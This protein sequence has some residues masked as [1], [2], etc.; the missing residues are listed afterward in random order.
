MAGSGPSRPTKIQHQ[1][2]IG[3]AVQDRGLSFISAARLIFLNDP[4]LSPDKQQQN[5]QYLNALETVWSRKDASEL[6]QQDLLELERLLIEQINKEIYNNEKKFKAVKD[7]LDNAE[8]H[9]NW[10]PREPVSSDMTHEAVKITRDETPFSRFTQEQTYA[11]T[12]I[13]SKEE[14]VQ[15]QWFK[16][17]APWEQNALR[18]RVEAWQRQVSK[19]DGVANLGEFLGPVP[20][21]IRRYPG[22]PNV[23]HTKA[24]IEGPQGKFEFKKI[25]SGVIVPAKMKHNSKKKKKQKVAIT[26]QNLEQILAEAIRTK[27]QDMPDAIPKGQTLDIPVLLQTLYSPPFQPPG[28]TYNNEAVLKATKNVRREL[29][30][31]P[32]SYLKKIGITEKDKK[33]YQVQVDMLYSNKPV[34]MLRGISWVLSKFN[35]S[36]REN[37]KTVKAFSKHIK[38]QKKALDQNKLP[39]KREDIHRQLQIAE[40]ALAAYKE[41]NMFG[42]TM[43]ATTIG[44]RGGKPKAVSERNHN[45]M[46]EK[47][48][49]EQIIMGN[50]GVRLGSCVSG[51]DREEMITHIALAQMEIY[52]KHGRFPPPHDKCTSDQDKLIRAEFV[53]AVARQYLSGHGHKLA[54]KNAMGCDGLKNVQDVFG[55][56]ICEQIQMLAPEYGIDPQVFDPVV[57]TQR[58]AGLNKLKEKKL[59]SEK[60]S[61][62]RLTGETM[63]EIYNNP[64]RYGIAVQE[65][66]ASAERGSEPAPRGRPLVIGYRHMQDAD[67]QA[68]AERR[69]AAESPVPSNSQAGPSHETPRHPRRETQRE[70][71]SDLSTRPRRNTF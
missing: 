21:T 71:I 66:A 26:Q 53:T 65:A 48:A 27:L 42:N 36:G 69:R 68:L 19:K 67:A 29:E 64:Q 54:G 5:L 40:Q 50:I 20:T 15:P 28:G 24:T 60:V 37:S 14:S 25:R 6:F 7:E 12:K 31:D 46:A 16:A 9:V 61:T 70:E 41:I 63:A 39:G 11:W 18:T 30:R 13:T 2:A 10:N 23:Y 57:D 1:G 8:N 34:N 51:K 44:I 55:R 58:L 38:K 62:A 4:K 3:K 17:L 49:L 52:A 47:A 32:E 33:G 59:T 22:A 56:E 43:K 45:A 35:R